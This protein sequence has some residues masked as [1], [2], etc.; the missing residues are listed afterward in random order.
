MTSVPIFGV[1]LSPNDIKTKNLP[2]DIEPSTS[3][4][5]KKVRSAS[6]RIFQIMV[7]V[8]SKQLF[9]FWSVITKH[10]PGVK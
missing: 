5:H 7:L 6:R 2:I 3:L 4:N 10:G 8:E 1:G 9:Y